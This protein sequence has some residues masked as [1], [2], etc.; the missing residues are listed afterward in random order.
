VLCFLALLLNP[1]F[2]LF[3]QKFGAPQC[4]H[5]LILASKDEM[6]LIWR[7]PFFILNLLFDLLNG[8]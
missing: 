5:W 4:T 6:L 1:S 2:L 8:I 3:K 7:Y